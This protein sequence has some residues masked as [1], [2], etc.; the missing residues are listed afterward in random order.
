M[1]RVRNATRRPLV[2]FKTGHV[3]G[4]RYVITARAGFIRGAG[5]VEHV[6]AGIEAVFDPVGEDSGAGG[7]MSIPRVFTPEVYPEDGLEVVGVGV[8]R[9]EPLPLRP[10]EVSMAF[11]LVQMNGAPSCFE[12]GILDEW[13]TVYE[14]REATP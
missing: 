11:K 13:D 5:I 9:G 12:W 7:E 14:I 1:T 6:S 2:R 8:E 4:I 10:D 3:T